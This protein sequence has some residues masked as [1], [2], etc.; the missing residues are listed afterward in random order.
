MWPRTPSGAQ[1][2]NLIN[3]LDVCDVH[4]GYPA[5]LALL[6]REIGASA[7]EQRRQL[8][9]SLSSSEATA[10]FTILTQQDLHL[11]ADTLHS[12]LEQILADILHS[13]RGLAFYPGVQEELS[14]NDIRD[15]TAC[16][17]AYFYMA[18]TL[19]ERRVRGTSS[20]S[21]AVQASA[22][23]IIR[24]FSSI[25]PSHG[26]SPAMAIGPPLFTGS[27]EPLDQVDC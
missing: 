27:C 13:S 19:I 4:F 11:D 25:Q 9:L 5:K 18:R 2:P 8:S 1:L 20:S 22:R 14:D 26:P 7:W 17:E 24:V 10:E 12:S 16:T 3:L 6:F 15:F 21:E 23:A